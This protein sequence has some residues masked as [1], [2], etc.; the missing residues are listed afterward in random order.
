M[1]NLRYIAAAELIFGFILIIGGIVSLIIPSISEY[2]NSLILFSLGIVAIGC[3]CVVSGA[4]GLSGRKFANVFFIPFLLL[5]AFFI[6]QS[7]TM[8]VTIIEKFENI[9]SQILTSLGL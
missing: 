9:I 5:S 2:V 6:I 4:L 8:G 1:R 3:G 7:L